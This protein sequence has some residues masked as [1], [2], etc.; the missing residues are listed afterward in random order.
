MDYQPAEKLHDFASVRAV[1][2]TSED[3]RSFL[4]EYLTTIRSEA[5]AEAYKT[6]SS[7]LFGTFQSIDS[8]L[9]KLAVLE[10]LP[11]PPEGAIEDNDETI[12]WLLRKNAYNLAAERLYQ[13]GQQ[14]RAFEIWHNLARGLYEDSRFSLDEC[15]KKVKRF[16]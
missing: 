10:G 11:P 4:K 3:C 6:V 2:A 1:K 9:V 7:T 12:D 15:L 13:S 5:W 16:V 8:A 14:P